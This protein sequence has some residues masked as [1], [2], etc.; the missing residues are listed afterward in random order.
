[1]I[2]R[3][4]QEFTSICRIQPCSLPAGKR[5]FLF[6]FQKFS[7]PAGFCLTVKAFETQLQVMISSDRLIASSLFHTA[8]YGKLFQVAADKNCK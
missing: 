6:H 1:M 2:D 7:V 8:V 3:M 5:C 4:S